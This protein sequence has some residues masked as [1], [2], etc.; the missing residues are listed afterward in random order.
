MHGRTFEETFVYQNLHLFRDGTIRFGKGIPENA[1][2][3]GEYQAVY[4]RVK[5]SSFKKTEFALDVASS[6]S[7]WATPQYIE[8]GLQWLEDQTALVVEE[9]VN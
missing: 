2:A 7:D 3:E 9:G 5:S 4:E 1:D 8:S 6:S